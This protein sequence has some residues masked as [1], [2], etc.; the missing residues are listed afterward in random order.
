[1]TQP[2]LGSLVDSEQSIVAQLMID[3]GIASDPLL[4]G[5]ASDWP[6]SADGELQNPDNVITVTGTEPARFGRVQVTG[7][8]SQISAVQIKVRSYD[9]QI[10]FTKTNEIVVWAEQTAYMQQTTVINQNGATSTYRVGPFTR[11]SGP[12]SVGRADNN[13]SKR[14]IYTINFLVSVIQ[15]S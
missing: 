6:V 14:W 9:P 13:L 10:A 15:L 4:P 11:K 1:M 8:G 3:M 7:E 12:L 5:T 2:L